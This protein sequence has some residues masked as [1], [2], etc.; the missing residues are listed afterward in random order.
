MKNLKKLSRNEL[1]TVTG[2]GAIGGPFPSV[3][4]YTHQWCEKVKKCIP[5]AIDCSQLE[6]PQPI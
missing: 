1:K 3:C 5:K 2:A 6:I 4:I